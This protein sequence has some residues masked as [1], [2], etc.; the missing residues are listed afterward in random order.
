VQPGDLC[1][2]CHQPH[3]QAPAKP[4]QTRRI[5]ALGIVVL[6]ILSITAVRVIRRSS[7]DEDATAVSEPDSSAAVAGASAAP[8]PV[9]E[10][11]SPE[12]SDSDQQ[13]GVHSLSNRRGQLLMRLADEPPSAAPD[14]QEKP[15][16]NS[17][18]PVAL[19]RLKPADLQ[20]LRG[21]KVPEA[22]AAKRRDLDS[23]YIHLAELADAPEVALGLSGNAVVAAYIHSYGERLGTQIDAGA[24]DNSPLLNMRTDLRQLPYKNGPATQLSPKAARL[25]DEAAR[26]MRVY[27]ELVAPVHRDESRHLAP[28]RRAKIITQVRNTRPDWLCPEVIPAL[29][30]ELA[31]DEPEP[32]ALLIELLAEIPGKA[33]TEAL[34]HRAL[35]DLNPDNRQAAIA[36]L[37][38]RREEDYRLVLLKAL[39]YPLASI[40]DH[41]AEA[42]V[43]LEDRRA[44]ATLVTLLSE[45]DPSAPRV[46]A[47][48][49]L[50]VQEVVRTLHVSNCMLCHPP[51]LFG[52]EPILAFDPVFAA[53]ARAGR[54]S[55]NG[56]AHSAV[57]L[58][59]NPGGY[60]ATR[61]TQN[62]WPRPPEITHPAQ[63][64]W[65]ALGNPQPTVIGSPWSNIT[66]GPLPVRNPKTPPATPAPTATAERALEVPERAPA[67][68]PRQPVQRELNRLPVEEAP[69]P[70]LPAQEM[71]ERAPE[72]R[73]AAE[74]PLPEKRA[75]VGGH[76]RGEERN[77]AA[78]VRP[79]E[80][81]VLGTPLTLAASLSPL[82]IR[83]DITFLREDFAVLLPVTLSPDAPPVN[84]RFDF[85]LRTRD[86]NKEERAILRTGGSEPSS[87]PQREAVLFALRELTGKDVGSTTLAWR[88]LYP[89]AEE[90]VDADRLVRKLVKSNPLE[91]EAQLTSLRDGPRLCC[92][93]AL[94]NA[95]P[96]L[97]AVSR[98]KAREFL[99]DRLAQMT[100]ASLRERL[101]DGNAEMRQAIIRACTR[102]NRKDMVPELIALSETNEPATAALAKSGLKEVTGRD[103]ATPQA[104]RSWWREQL[105]EREVKSE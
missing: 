59:R 75:L 44:V 25:L 101:K 10:A 20:A 89:I 19:N 29:L 82:L 55:S 87:Y 96:S 50:S 80:P 105:P 35:F 49:R 84:L 69:A 32:R 30:Q 71:R 12:H 54:L 94:A 104:W 79:N 76:N 2:R 43:A 83:G 7:H 99:T 100:S 6:V 13:A 98:E 23:E 57:A 73:L 33:A 77:L 93:L 11:S 27:L 48:N 97:P 103:F 42:L 41:G 3:L 38:T 4:S 64:K 78:D 61:G 31:H 74:R 63:G 22:P 15:A 37:R 1:A 85:M 18:T 51:S 47:G 62:L 102:T 66:F 52:D 45:P 34:A 95:I 53:P 28:D 17:T 72:P 46:R 60:M 39:R 16:E 86:A 88:E 8:S 68:Q 90:E 92:T 91:Q 5:V 65:V 70:R 9:A 58:N 24:A 26:A 40:A 81:R 56:Y 67:G 21:K 14:K 36:A